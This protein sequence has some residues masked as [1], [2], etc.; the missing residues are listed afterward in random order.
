M[1]FLAK[2]WIIYSMLAQC[3]P[4]EDMQKILGFKWSYREGWDTVLSGQSQGSLPWESLFGRQSL[5]KLMFEQEIQAEACQMWVMVLRVEL[6]PQQTSQTILLSKCQHSPNGILSSTFHQ[7]EVWSLMQGGSP[8][9]WIPSANHLIWKDLLERQKVIT[10][11]FSARIGW[12]QSG[13]KS[14][15]QSGNSI[16]RWVR[17]GK[18]KTIY[19]ALLKKMV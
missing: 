13:E 8:L 18:L 19:L 7:N 3:L 1:L 5:G 6:L 11:F 4:S 2:V 14:V 10:A 15:A 9:F 16:Q 12:V 17:R